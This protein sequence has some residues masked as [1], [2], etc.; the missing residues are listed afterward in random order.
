MN[1]IKD[2]Q[3]RIA[4][5][6]TETKNPCKTYATEAGAEKAAEKMAARGAEHF[7]A[8]RPANF[9]IVY[10]PELGR[11][12]PAFAINELLARPETTGGYVGIFGAAGFYTY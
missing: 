9:I 4:R 2:L 8:N 7:G 11:Y 10:V 12:T 3:A 1:V 5:R 6:L